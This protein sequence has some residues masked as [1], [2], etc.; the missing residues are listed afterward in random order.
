MKFN[1]GD[2]VWFRSAT[3]P[4]V[5]KGHIIKCLKDGYYLVDDGTGLSAR[6]KHGSVLGRTQPKADGVFA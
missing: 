2:R 3:S 5:F 1:L 6:K 4:K